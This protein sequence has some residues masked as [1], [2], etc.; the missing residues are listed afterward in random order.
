VLQIA[1]GGFFFHGPFF[2]K[3]CAASETGVNMQASE[4]IRYRDSRTVRHRG[5]ETRRESGHPVALALSCSLSA[6]IAV[7]WLFQPGRGYWDQLD[8]T[9]FRQLNGTLRWGMV[10]QNVW[11]VAN[12]RPFDGVVGLVVL[13]ILLF[14][15]SRRF[16]RQPLRAFASL[17]TLVLATVTIT[18]VA[19]EFLVDKMFC[20]H[21]GSPTYVLEDTY[22]LNSLVE[23]VECKDTSAWSF[24]GDHGFV[25]FMSALYVTYLGGKRTAILAWLAAFV[26]VLPRLISGAHWATDIIVGS[27]TMALL[28]SAFLFATPL[29]D[30]L[31]SLVPDRVLPSWSK[32]NRHSAPEENPTEPARAADRTLNRSSEREST[33]VS[34]PRPALRT[35]ETAL[36]PAAPR[37]PAVPRREA[38]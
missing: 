38:G 33:A 27:G 10:W 31:V 35:D 8:L 5:G 4:S 9:V 3:F 28:T 6:I 21:R 18:E 19:S 32:G 29:H 20:Y 24:P 34:I 14:A 11:A 16:P 7:T 30:S 15:V 2:L 22:R 1:I 37:S 13:V 23:W 36:L 12:W 26:F 17:L 25:L